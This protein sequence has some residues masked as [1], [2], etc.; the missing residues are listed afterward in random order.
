MNLEREIQAVVAAIR[1]VE[2]CA[3]YYAEVRAC[4]GLDGCDECLEL[5]AQN[6]LKAA[7]QSWLR[8]SPCAYPKGVV[9][10]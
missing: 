7:E 8:A 9:A 4:D 2:R 6:A 10:E 1:D 5:V 3:D